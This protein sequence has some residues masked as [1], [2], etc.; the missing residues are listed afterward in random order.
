[1]FR[2]SFISN[3]FAVAAAIPVGIASKA[4]EPDDGSSVIKNCT[5]EGTVIVR[6]PN[7]V[8]ENCEIIVP[9]AQVASGH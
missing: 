3:L 2:R 5:I 8:V 9:S 7:A 1:M 6:G 4:A